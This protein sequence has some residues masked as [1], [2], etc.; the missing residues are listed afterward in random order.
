[1]LGSG[2]RMK[3]VRA[4]VRCINWTARLFGATAILVGIVMLIS[5]Y[6]IGEHRAMNIVIGILA[7]AMGVATFLA[8]PV[9]VDAIDRMRRSMGR[10]D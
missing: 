6:L 5:A 2:P 1:M 10:S 7:I 9:T 8:K 3:F 4:Y